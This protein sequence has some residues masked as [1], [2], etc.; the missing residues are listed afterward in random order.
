MKL[1]KY[2]F[3]L[4]LSTLTA[5][6]YADSTVV[7]EDV[8]ILSVKVMWS[9]SGVQLLQV[10]TSPLSVTC[11]ADPDGNNFAYMVYLTAFDDDGKYYVDYEKYK[12]NYATVNAAVAADKP[13]N[14]T[15]Y[16]YNGACYLR[17]AGLKQRVAST[18]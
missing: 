12:R 10:V 9:T 2:A 17:A 14:L 13:A 4:L 7:E 6:S 18:M 5:Y 8:E 3:A 1:F 16:E 15:I 11:Y